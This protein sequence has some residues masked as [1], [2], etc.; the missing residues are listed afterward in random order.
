MKS[1]SRVLAED[2]V[3]ERDRERES[4]RGRLRLIICFVFAVKLRKACVEHLHFAHISAPPPPPSPPS[5]A[6]S[7]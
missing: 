6:L 4:G 1:I 2:R 7:N 5:R 3:C